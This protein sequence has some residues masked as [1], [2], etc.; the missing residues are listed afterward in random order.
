MKQEIDNQKSEALVFCVHRIIYK[1]KSYP[2][3]PYIVP[4]QV[5]STIPYYLISRQLNNRDS[6]GPL[7][8]MQTLKTQRNVN[9]NS[10]QNKNEM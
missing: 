7:S 9:V 8:S 4:N 5:K 2:Q 10:I 6:N 1:K 3:Y